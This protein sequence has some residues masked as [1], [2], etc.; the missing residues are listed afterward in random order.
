[1]SRK[2]K[3]VA[4]GKSKRLPRLKYD[5]RGLIPA[6]IQDYKTK[7]VLMLAYMNRKSL[8]ITLKEAKTCFYSRSRKVYWRKGETSGN[9]QKIRHIYY[10]CD[11][12]SL[13]IEVEQ[14]GVACHTGKRSCFF[15]RIVWETQTTNKVASS[16]MDKIPNYKFQITN[17]FQYRNYND[18]NLNY[19]KYFVCNFGHLVIV[20]CL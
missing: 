14:I 1:M 19:L 7:Q 13:L 16:E 5:S 3:T 18:Q 11:K 20:Y 6:I 2:T 10:D 8:K 17:K 12:D 15:R 9:I 4:L